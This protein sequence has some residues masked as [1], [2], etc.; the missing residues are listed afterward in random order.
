[1]AFALLATL[2]AA[3]GKAAQE[4]GIPTD[5]A[6]SSRAGD[7][8][9]ASPVNPA[10][11][12]TPGVVTPAAPQIAQDQD[13]PSTI[14]EDPAATTQ[15]EIVSRREDVVSGKLACA[16]DV[17]YPGAVDQPVVWNG[18]GCRAVTA[19]FVDRARLGRLGKYDTLPAEARDDIARADGKALYVEG[20]FSSSLYPLNSAGRIYELPLAD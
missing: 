5:A 16:L 4:P 9:A 17:R 10:P 13:L 19:M 20:Q 2:T 18:E 8:Q 14:D 15:A 6:T 11:A 7:V 12:P 3:C 1:M